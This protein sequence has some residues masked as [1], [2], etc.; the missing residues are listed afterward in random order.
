MLTCGEPK[1]MYRS[2]YMHCLGSR[3]PPSARRKMPTH[4]SA[5]TA[6]SAPTMAKSH[7]ASRAAAGPAATS[8]PSIRQLCSTC[9]WRCAQ[10]EQRAARSARDRRA[11]TGSKL[12]PLFA[13][14]DQ[15]WVG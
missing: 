11:P 10:C 12:P 5:A 8:M 4:R 3:R 6:S 2:S 13:A 15:Q 1:R 14:T 7:D 9:A